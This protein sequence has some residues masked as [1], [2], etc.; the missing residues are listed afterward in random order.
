MSESDWLFGGWHKRYIS[1]S[2]IKKM[3]SEMK[4]ATD[5]RENVIKVKE[6]KKKLQEEIEAENLLTQFDEKTTK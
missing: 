3:K 6:D 2:Q 4:Q 5:K 1:K